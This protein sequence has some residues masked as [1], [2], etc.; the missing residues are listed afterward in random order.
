MRAQGR[1]LKSLSFP[2]AK[3]LRCLQLIKALED[4]GLTVEQMAA[5][6]DMSVRTAYRYVA[7]FEEV[8]LIID[9]DF[10]RKFFIVSNLELFKN[11]KQ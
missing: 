5:K 3:L 6:F 9:R 4:G 8:G 7:L 1:P 10:K 2:A 11:L